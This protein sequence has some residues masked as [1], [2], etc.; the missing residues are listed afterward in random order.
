MLG[1][2]AANQRE[3]KRGSVW[4]GRE[5]KPGREGTESLGSLS[6]EDCVIVYQQ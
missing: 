4:E 6:W 5:G 1:A 2:K 3:T